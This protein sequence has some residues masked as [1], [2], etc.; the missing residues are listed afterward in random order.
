LTGIEINELFEAKV[1]NSLEH[2]DEYI[3]ATGLGAI[4]VR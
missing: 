2:F 1:R 3:D 4:N